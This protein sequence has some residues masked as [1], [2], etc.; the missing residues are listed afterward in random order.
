V[1]A[2]L[3]RFP[4]EADTTLQFGNMTLLKREQDFF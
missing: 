3:E 4:A 1:I 2:P